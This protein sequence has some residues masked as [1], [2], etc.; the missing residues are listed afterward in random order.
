MD[1]GGSPSLLP[2]ALQQSPVAPAATATG[3]SADVPNIPDLQLP[4]ATSRQVESAPVPEGPVSASTE[5]GVRNLLSDVAGINSDEEYSRDER[6]L[7]EF[8][9]LHPM[10]SLYV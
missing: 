10:L 3:V 4:V 9:K 8:T 7:N 5:S 1:D 6:L 2:E